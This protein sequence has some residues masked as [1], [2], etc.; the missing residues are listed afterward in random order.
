[1]LLV[2]S[3]GT[4]LL[5]QYGIA[6]PAG[7]VVR[8][9]AWAAPNAPRVVKAQVTVGGRGKAGGVALTANAA[10]TQAALARILG[11]RIKGHAVTACLVEA[12]AS[13]AEWYLSIM[14]DAGAGALRVTCIAEGGVEVESHALDASNS[15]LCAPD[16]ASIN[17]TLAALTSNP[18]VRQVGAALATLFLREELMLAEIN[19]LFVQGETATAGDAKL[20]LDGNAL[21]RQPGQEAL[22]RANAALYPDA[23]RKL[24][25]G[26]DYVELDA[27]GSLGLL[28]TGA[29][30]SM[31]L[32]DELTTQ[33]VRPINFLDIRTGQLRGSPARLIRVLEW[34]SEHPSLKVIF[35][36]IFAGITDQRE[37]AQ[38]LVAALAE[39][40][41][42]GVPVVARLVGNGSEDARIWLAETRPDIAIFEELEASIA[43]V[44]ELAA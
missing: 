19:P 33:G 4:A 12:P 36:N 9:A 34:L 35:V 28:T 44:A 39:Q 3:A 32:V 6:V 43:K 21:H 24:D 31:M 5:R 20:V 13:G 30:L 22:L 25:E 42:G 8:N 29:G 40:P 11:S 18:A 23:L 10:E 17:A 41:C 26:F 7:E 1:M 2:E 38:L 37:F 14:L 16:E 15:R 27:Q